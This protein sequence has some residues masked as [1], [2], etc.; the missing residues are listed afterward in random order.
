VILASWGIAFA[1]YCFQV[2]ANRIGHAR[3]SASQLKVMQEVITLLVFGTFTILYLKESPRWNELVGFGLILLAVL[4]VFGM[5]SRPNTEAE[6]A[7]TSTTA[8]ASIDTL[9]ETQL[10][11][12]TVLPEQDI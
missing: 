11:A 3:F 2:P 9:R 8:P 10:L 12:D 5:G 7:P 4:F 6:A 1:E